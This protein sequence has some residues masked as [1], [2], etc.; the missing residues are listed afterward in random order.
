MKYLTGYSIGVGGIVLRKN[1]ILMARGS[2]Q[3]WQLPGGYVECNETIESAIVREVTEETSLICKI[4]SIVALRNRTYK[5]ASSFLND[6]Y[7]VF[8]LTP[9]NDEDPK[10]DGIEVIETVFMDQQQIE[11][12]KNCPQIFKSIVKL[13]LS[14]KERLVRSDTFE[15]NPNSYVLYQ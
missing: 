8:K 2:N 11:N 14:K 9:I 15:K 6:T 12:L 10:P 3:V 5:P 7:I 1:K 4:N 13:A